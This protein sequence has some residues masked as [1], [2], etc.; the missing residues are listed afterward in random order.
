M[1]FFAIAIAFFGIGITG[2]R[3]LLILGIVF[4]VLAIIQLSRTSRQ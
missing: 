1:A 3:T 2:H 4:L